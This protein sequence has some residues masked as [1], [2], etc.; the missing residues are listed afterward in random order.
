M[1]EERAHEFFDMK[2]GQQS[3]YMLLVVPVSEAKRLPIPPDKAGS[4][5]IDKLK[6]L[7]SVVPRSR[8]S[9]IRARVQT[10]D[11]ERHG[12]FRRLMENSTK[13]PAAP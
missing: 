1:L 4:K 7:R 8:T 10:I 12:L 6:L 13:R 3:P 9:I 5:G 2:E 11:K